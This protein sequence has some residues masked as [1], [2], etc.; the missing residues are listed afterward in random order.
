MTPTAM[1][2]LTGRQGNQC[3]SAVMTA[4]EIAVT[5]A[6]VFVMA[7]AAVL[8]SQPLLCLLR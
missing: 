4:A 8:L 7:T 6:A 5:D 2:G 3:M 1:S